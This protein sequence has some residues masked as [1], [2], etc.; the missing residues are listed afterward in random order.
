[1]G[2]TI[3]LFRNSQTY[4]LYDDDCGICTKSA[5]FI[6]RLLHS[7][8][9]IIQMHI[10]EVMKLGLSKFDHEEY[11]TSFHIVKGDLWTSEKN[12]ILELANHFPLNKFCRKIA[13][14]TPFMTFFMFLLKRAQEQRNAE[15][16]VDFS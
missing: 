11:W 2:Y 6:G 9:K 7:R 14:L 15:C 1:M 10:P 5:K 8:I 13:E 3:T 4:L 16:K 12:A